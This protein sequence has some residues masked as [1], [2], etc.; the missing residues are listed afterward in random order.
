VFQYSKIAKCRLAAWSWRE[1]LS[2]DSSL[3]SDYFSILSR[4]CSEF[5]G[6]SSSPA[7]SSTL[8]STGSPL[9]LPQP[10]PSTDLQ[11][12]EPGSAAATE[13]AAITDTAALSPS[14]CHRQALYSGLT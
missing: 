10:Q 5:F 3:N 9:Q 2:C 14:L 7:A 6:S 12:F 4:S 13:Q 1:E 8:G 11:C